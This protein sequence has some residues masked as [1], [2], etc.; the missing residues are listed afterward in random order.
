MY[1]RSRCQ[2]V[3]VELPLLAEGN[4]APGDDRARSEGIVVAC[5]WR[6]TCL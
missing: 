1:K 5:K 3:T 4:N 2:Q 6:S